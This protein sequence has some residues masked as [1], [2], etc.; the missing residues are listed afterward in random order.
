MTTFKIFDKNDPLKYALTYQK[1][2]TIEYDPIDNGTTRYCKNNDWLVGIFNYL[3]CL[4]PDIKPF[5]VLAFECS[6]EA[7]TVSFC[8]KNGDIFD[9]TK[10]YNKPY[11]ID[12]GYNIGYTIAQTCVYDVS[13]MTPNDILNYRIKFGIDD[14]TLRNVILPF[15]ALDKSSVCIDKE[16]ILGTPVTFCSRFRSLDVLGTIYREWEIKYPD[17]AEVYINQYC[18]LNPDSYDCLYINRSDSIYYKSFKVTGIINDECWF[19]PGSLKTNNQYTDYLVLQS[20]INNYDK[21]IGTEYKSVTYIPNDKV[22]ETT[23]NLFLLTTKPTP[24]PTPDPDPKPP[25]PPDPTTPF[26]KNE[27]FIVFIIILIVLLLIIL[28]RR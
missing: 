16:P 12:N 22:D 18:G 23:A 19:K 6:K 3:T 7:T 9:Y 21:C 26:Y 20:S 4:P 28:S 2:I 10:G 8:D 5:T 14:P 11:F 13:K 1:G 17:E 25:T 24:T 27:Y 15:Y